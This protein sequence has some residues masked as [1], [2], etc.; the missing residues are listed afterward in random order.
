MFRVITLGALDKDETREAMLRPIDDEDCP[1]TLTEGSIDLLWNVTQGYPYFIQFVCRECYD[2]WI[3]NLNEEQEPSSIPVDAITRKLDTD[4]FSGRWARAT[5]RQ[6]DLLGIV[7]QLANCNQ[8]FSVQDV[9]GSGA[10]KEHP[11]PFSS[12]HVNQILNSLIA[13]GLVYKNRH[14]R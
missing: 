10:N 4:F 13:A 8:E 2:V 7:A 6:R 12:S 11:K 14:G 5:D 1:I 9:V 3:Q